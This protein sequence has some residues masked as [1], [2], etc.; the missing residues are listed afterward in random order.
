MIQK[1]RQLYHQENRFSDDTKSE[2]GAWDNYACGNTSSNAVDT[3]KRFAAQYN[4][5]GHWYYNN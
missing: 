3:L 2:C 4:K 1:N 5:R